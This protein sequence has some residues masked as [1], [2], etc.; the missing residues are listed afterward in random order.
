MTALT[1]F[2]PDDAAAASVGADRVAAALDAA[3]K[4]RSLHLTL[5]RTGSRGLLWLEPLLEVER[6]G[7]RVGFGPLE[8]DDAASVLDAVLGDGAHAKAVGAVEEIPYFAKQTRSLFARCGVIDP[9]DLGGFR[10]AGGLA[11][12]DAARAMAPADIVAAVT[13]SG[14]R[15]RGGA[16]FPAGIKWNTV[17]AA[18]GEQKYVCCNADEGDSGTFAD[19]MLMEG[20]PFTLLAGMA[21]AGR[22]S[23]AREGYVYIRSEYP[24]AI[25]KMRA[26]VAVWER[27]NVSGE[28]DRGSLFSFHI[29]VGAGS[30]VCGEETSM[31]ESLEGQRGEVRAKP[32]IPALKGLFGK[33]TV[34][35]NVLTL[36]SVPAIL[37]RGADWYASLG[38]GR[39]TGTQAFQLAG[40]VKRGGLVELPFGVALR[41][42]IDGYGGGT[43]SGRPVRAV[44]LGGPLGA[45]VSADQLDVA[46]GYESL[47]EIGAML[48]HG[49]IVV[50]DDSV[51]MARQARFAM[52]FCAIE[53]CGKCTPCR[54]GA[55]RGRETIDKILAG[56]DVDANLALIEDLCEVMTDGSLCAMGGLTPMPVLSAIKGW[57]EDFRKARKAAE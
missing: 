3:A 16:G 10:A 24:R 50:F 34:V 1:L 8:A 14:L 49:G 11:G 51:D 21:I 43:L 38:A 44:Q 12:W 52:D 23:G 53:S 15:G 27:D 6:A 2:L 55:V 36:A 48:G 31:L 29:R 22:A 30:Y 17:L 19:R 56:D 54:L 57:P 39:S 4:T 37:E 18:A 47:A 41:E 7:A 28:D 25:A 45:Y 32:P 46:M 33:P 9:L 13:A 42:L 35:N 26:A 40:N 20:D 5:V